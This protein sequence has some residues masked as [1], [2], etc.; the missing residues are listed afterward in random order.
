MI[1][2]RVT[3]PASAVWLGGLGLVPFLGLTAAL[4][5]LSPELQ[6]AVSHALIA[7]GATILSFLGGVHWGLGI[8]RAASVDGSGLAGRL[9]LSI[10]PSLV[11]WAALLLPPFGG[12]LVLAAG[13]ALMLPV[14]VLATRGGIAPA[15][16]PRLRIPLS[17]AVASALLG[18]CFLVR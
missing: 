9:T 14:D 8:A 18:A 1:P 11:A 17:F 10:V 12:L 6:P 5:L 4:S 16:Y 13:I 3:V 2:A 7:Y 15:W